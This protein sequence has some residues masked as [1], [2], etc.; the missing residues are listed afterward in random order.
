MV[1]E[2]SGT[3]TEMSMIYVL[4]KQ[5]DNAYT[6]KTTTEIPAYKMKTDATT[7]YEIEA[8]KGENKDAPKTETGNEKISVP[9]GE[10]DCQW[11]KTYLEQGWSKVWL[12]DKV[13]GRIVKSESEMAGS[14]SKMELIELTKK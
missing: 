9:A 3:K 13:P 2:A 11:V 6:V 10:F 7:E 5:G 12:S 4:V 1:S 14:K 8:A